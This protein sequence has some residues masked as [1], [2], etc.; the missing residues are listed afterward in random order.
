M[1]FTEWFYT[2]GDDLLAGWLRAKEHGCD[3]TFV[4]WVR[5]ERGRFYNTEDYTVPYTGQPPS[6]IETL[7]Y[8]EDS[9]INLMVTVY[10]GEDEPRVTFIEA[11]DYQMDRHKEKQARFA[12]IYFVP[13]VELSEALSLGVKRA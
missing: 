7:I 11:E 12:D 5:G 9:P 10:H 4:D 6:V 2:F 13:L 3:E 8:G 1:E